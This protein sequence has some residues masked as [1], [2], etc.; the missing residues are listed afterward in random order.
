[1][2]DHVE[3]FDWPRCPACGARRTTQCPI[4]QTAGT[5]F[6]AAD[7]P[8]P[9]VDMP[10][11]AVEEGCGTCGGGTCAGGATACADGEGDASCPPL[12]VC[13]TCDEPF[14]PEYL[15]ACEWCGHT[16]AEGRPAAEEEPAEEINAVTIVLSLGLALLLL[17]MLAWFMFVV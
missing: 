11:Q 17:G 15:R 6:A 5:D 1:M 3:T 7:P 8:E 14:R 10:E 9:I 4:C 2:E 16:F 13:P 12:L